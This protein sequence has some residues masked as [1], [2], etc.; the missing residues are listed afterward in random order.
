MGTLDSVNT[1]Q[2]ETLHKSV[3]EAYQNSN[4]VN[5]AAQMCFWD[6]RRLA[7]EV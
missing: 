6:D 2:I 3:K 5:Y 4:K 7:V 1:S